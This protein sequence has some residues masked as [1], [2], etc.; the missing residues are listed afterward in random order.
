MFPPESS[1][2]P[3]RGRVL[4]RLSPSYLHGGRTG[5]SSRINLPSSLLV[6]QSGGA[7]VSYADPGPRVASTLSHRSSRPEPAAILVARWIEDHQHRGHLSRPARQ[8]LGAQVAFRRR[9]EGRRHV[10]GP[11][12]AAPCPTGSR[13]PSPRPL[14]ESRNKESTG[15]CPAR[16]RNPAREGCE[17]GGFA[18]HRELHADTRCRTEADNTTVSYSDLVPAPPVAGASL[19]LM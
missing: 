5:R 14:V 2:A 19:S 15:A 18:D 16:L 1:P 3:S 10:I 12:D 8:G 17:P 4:P 7:A 11:V 6:S 13:G 9:L